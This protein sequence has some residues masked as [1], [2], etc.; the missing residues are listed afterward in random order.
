M[1]GYAFIENETGLIN[2][3]CAWDDNRELAEDYPIPENC[4]AITIQDFESSG[5]T[6]NTHKY[7][8]ELAKFEEYTPDP[9]ELG[10][11][12]EQLTMLAIAELDNQRQ[13]DKLETQ[14]A[15]AELTNSLLGGV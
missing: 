1:K 5:I 3:I 7:N 15:I 14:L 8:F 6:F 4:V 2:S 13:Q 10:P 9:V 12:Q 11:T